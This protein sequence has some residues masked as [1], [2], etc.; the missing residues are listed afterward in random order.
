MKEVLTK[1]DIDLPARVTLLNGEVANG[2]Q[3]LSKK[4]IAIEGFVKKLAATCENIQ[5]CLLRFIAVY[6]LFYVVQ[7][8]RVIWL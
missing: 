2:E 4:I 1:D 8:C 5:V 7:E 3:Q 6:E